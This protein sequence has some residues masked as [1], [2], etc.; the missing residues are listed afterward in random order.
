MKNQPTDVASHAAAFPD[1]YEAT[2]HPVVIS[3][4]CGPTGSRNGSVGI[5][6]IGLPDT[7]RDTDDDFVFHANPLLDMAEHLGL[8]ESV[9]VN[10]LAY[11]LSLQDGPN[12]IVG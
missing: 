10:Q 1:V 4:S 6:P 5:R 8:S 11:W 2:T 3:R 9:Y 7:V 12:H